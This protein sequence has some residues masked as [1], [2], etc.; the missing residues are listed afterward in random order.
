MAVGRTAKGRLKKGYTIKNGRT[1][2]ASKSK[3]RRRRK[4]R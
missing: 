2:K 3:T 1:V 4:R